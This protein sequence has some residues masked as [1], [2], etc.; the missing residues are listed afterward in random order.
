MVDRREYIGAKIYGEGAVSSS[1]VHNPCYQ[2]RVENQERYKRRRKVKTKTTISAA[3][4]KFFGT[5]HQELRT[6][7]RRHDVSY[8]KYFAN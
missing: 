3:A 8:S 4:K 1:N 2:T 5:Y 7:H 6:I